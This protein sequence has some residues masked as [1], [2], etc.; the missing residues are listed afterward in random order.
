V[1]EVIE[2]L[3]ANPM[4]CLA[5][6]ED[7]EPRV[8]PWGFMF[9]QGEKLYFCT[10]S[11]K[12]AYAQMQKN[13]MVEFTSRNSENNWVRVRGKAI[14]TEDMNLVERIF[15]DYSFLRQM[16]QTPD[17]PIFRLFYIEH[18]KAVLAYFMGEPPRKFEF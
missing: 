10:N 7:G 2:F 1:R 12:E 6:V 14:F 11:T 3:K 5:T 16:Y 17:N 18:G 4:G 8:R 15:E 13:P 9:E